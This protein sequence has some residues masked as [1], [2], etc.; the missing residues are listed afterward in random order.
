LTHYRPYRNVIGIIA[1]SPPPGSCWRRCSMS[2]TTTARLL[3][4]QERRSAT[5]WKGVMSMEGEA[6]EALVM[7]K[8]IKLYVPLPIPSDGINA[9]LLIMHYLAGWQEM[10]GFKKQRARDGS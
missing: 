3:R 10:D 1:N 6:D 5:S 2:T 9:I 8:G 7:F 4:R